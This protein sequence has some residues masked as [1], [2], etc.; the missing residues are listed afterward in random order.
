MGGGGHPIGDL[1]IQYYGTHMLET[2]PEGK[3][4]YFHESEGQ[5]PSTSAFTDSADVSGAG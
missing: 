1:G 5:M 2:I 4:I 3:S